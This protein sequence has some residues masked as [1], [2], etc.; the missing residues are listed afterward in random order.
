MY[1][2]AK[3]IKYIVSKTINHWCRQESKE[4]KKAKS[5]YKEKQR[6]LSKIWL[7]Y[8]FKKPTNYYFKHDFWRTLYICQLNCR[9]IAIVMTILRYFSRYGVFP[10]ATCMYIY[11]TG[12]IKSH[13]CKSSIPCRR[14][15]QHTWKLVLRCMHTLW[16]NI[17]LEL[18]FL[19]CILR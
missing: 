11:H 4:T 16:K 13:L 9:A 7:A 14:E 1:M 5:R 17:A 19:E 12:S 10:R 6:A 8:L 3:P 18:I 15:Q 2:F